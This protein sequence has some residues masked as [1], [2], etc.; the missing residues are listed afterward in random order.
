MWQFFP[1]YSEGNT[2]YLLDEKQRELASLE[3]PRQPGADGL[4]LADYANPREA[5]ARD[6]VCLFAVT[7]GKGIRGLYQ[8]TG[9]PASTSRATPSRRWRLRP[10]RPAPSGC[11]ARSAVLGFSDHPRMTMK[12]RFQARYPGRRY[13]FG[14]PACPD[15]AL[16]KTLFELLWPEEIGIQLTEKTDDGSGG[17]RHRSS[18]FH[19]P[20]ASTST[21]A[22]RSCKRVVPHRFAMTKWCPRSFGLAKGGDPVKR[23]TLDGFDERPPGAEGTT[24]RKRH[25]L[26]LKHRES[27]SVEG[28]INVEVLTTKR[29]WW[30]PI[31]G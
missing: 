31:K 11:I 30:R 4:C 28:V 22:K 7:A 26:T 13:S 27:M 6:N 8:D 17:L 15:L 24:P 12:E 16:Q 5:K 2:L 14:Y 3:F 10:P 25:Q 18:V 29:C 1:A 19:H 23:R 20:R 21:P 9:M